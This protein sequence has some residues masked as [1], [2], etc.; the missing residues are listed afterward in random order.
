VR[1]KSAQRSQIKLREAISQRGFAGDSGGESV[2]EQLRSLRNSQDR[3]GMFHS[4]EKRK[5]SP[6]LPVDPFLRLCH[7]QNMAKKPSKSRTSARKLK[8]TAQRLESSVRQL[9]DTIRKTEDTTHGLEAELSQ[10]GTNPRKRRQP[11]EGF[12]QLG[13]PGSADRT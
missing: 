13:V 7:S 4:F 2:L 12:N 10:R 1:E 6:V 5:P 11:K 3:R 8:K 9:E